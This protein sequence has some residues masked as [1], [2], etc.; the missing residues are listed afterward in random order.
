MHRFSR[1][2]LPLVTCVG[3]PAGRNSKCWSSRLTTPARA[4]PERMRDG[5]RIPTGVSACCSVTTTGIVKQDLDISDRPRQ[6]H[7]AAARPGTKASP[8]HFL[9]RSQMGRFH[10]HCAQGFRHEE[11]Y[12]DAG[13]QR[14]EH[15]N[16]RHPG[17]S[18]GTLALQGRERKHAA[19]RQ[20]Q[21]NG[22]VP[23]RSAR[24]EYVADAR[25]PRR[26]IPWNLPLWVA[27]DASADSGSA[28]RPRTPAMVTHSPGASFAALARSRLRTND[29]RLRMR[30][31]KRQI[32]P[33]SA[34][35]RPRQ[36]PSASLENTSCAWWPTIG[37]ATVAEGSNAAGRTLR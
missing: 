16:S 20:L 25:T 2:G 37:R 11:T 12:V 31:S 14:E 10:H 3:A 18:V 15:G 1:C 21:R 33:V 32:P 27:D 8:T 29:P 19:V 36:R 5:S 35:K 22:A 24:A 23:A 30:I 34:A 17:Y 4:S 26:P 28:N 6:S 13:R 9:P 7:R